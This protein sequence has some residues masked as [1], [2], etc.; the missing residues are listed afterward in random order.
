MPKVKPVRKA[1]LSKHERKKKKKSQKSQFFR[2]FKES[3]GIAEIFQTAK[4]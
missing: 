2:T 3:V 4:L 1:T